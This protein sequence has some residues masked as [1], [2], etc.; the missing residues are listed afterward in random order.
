MTYDV[1]YIYIHILHDYTCTSQC[2]IYH[3]MMYASNTLPPR[4]LCGI[5]V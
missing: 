1:S 2:R 5:I 3:N 4:M